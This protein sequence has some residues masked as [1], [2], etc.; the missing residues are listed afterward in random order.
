MFNCGRVTPHAEMAVDLDEA[1]ASLGMGRYQAQL[2]S[3][4]ALLVMTEAMECNLLTFLS[5]CVA[6]AWGLD[7]VDEATLSSIV[8]GVSL[9]GTFF[10]GWAADSFGRWTVALVCAFANSAFGVLSAVAGRYWVLVAFRAVVGFSIGGMMQP[11][12]MLMEW[13]PAKT[14][15]AWAMLCTSISWVLGGMY[16]YLVAWA[17]LASDARFS[18][19]RALVLMCA[20]P[21]WLAFAGLWLLHESPRWLLSR[22]RADDA[23]AVLRAVAETNGRK[24]DADALALGGGGGDDEERAPPGALA[25]LG[26]L[27]ARP[28]RATTL[29]LWALWLA[30][31]LQYYGVVL[32]ISEAFLRDRGDEETCS[33][34][35]FSFLFIVAA[36]EGVGDTV[37][38]LCV[39][40]L[41]RRRLQMVAYA[42]TAIATTTLAVGVDGKGSLEPLAA[43][44]LLPVA[45]LARA[46][47]GASTSGSWVQTPELIPTRLRGFGSG[48]CLA[49]N[50]VGNMAICYW[51]WD[52]GYSYFYRALGVAF[53]GAAAAALAAL[54]PETAGTTLTE[55]SPAR[56]RQ[57]PEADPE[58]S[59]PLL[60][61]T[62]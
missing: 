44:V 31:G 2:L 43:G 12:V 29:T 46:A 59:Q 27:L 30:F 10:F 20:L 50:A 37:A 22:G 18:G 6:V 21:G 61:A 19:W 51:V 58:R 38:M 32:L 57:R 41:G 34:F 42:L 1:I 4:I 17:V 40:T 9:L 55:G 7:S 47:N 49:A 53:C 11:Y 15:G 23:L 5:P 33:G 24:L 35:H 13:L 39:D 60:E 28:L 8:F 48:T 62:T 16:V 45:M 54:L 14:R 25:L 52:S 36:A 56:A 26:E 3:V